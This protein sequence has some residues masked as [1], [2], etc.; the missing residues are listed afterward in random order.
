MKKRNFFTLATLFVALLAHSQQSAEARALLDKSYAAFETSKGIHLTF[1]ATTTGSDGSEQM[2]MEGTAYIRGNKFKLET[3][4]MDIWFDGTTQWVLMKEINEVNISN[5]TSEE[6]TAVSPLAL[7]G[8]Y[9]NGYL[10]SA[11]VSRTIHGKKLQ[12]IRM[13]P[14]TDNKAYKSV[15][16]LIDPNGLALKEVMLTLRNGTIQMITISGYNANHNFS[17]AEFR[18]D[19]SRYPHA[20]IIDLR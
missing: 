19:R 11:P 9:R 13:T 2:A 10:L 6:I 15:D 1:R 4:E 5:P 17:D 16:A 14:A 18:F 20:E 7:L 3:N 8:I 12:L